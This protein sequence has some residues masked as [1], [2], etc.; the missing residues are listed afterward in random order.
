MQHD[1]GPSLLVA[2]QQIS[3]ILSRA[4]GEIA[5]TLGKLPNQEVVVSKPVL[6]ATLVEPVEAAQ[7]QAAAPEVTAAPPPLDPIPPPR[8]TIPEFNTVE[9]AA[10]AVNRSPAFVYG[11]INRGMIAKHFPFGNS[12]TMVSMEEVK[13][14]VE[15]ISPGQ[16][17]R[18][19]APA[20]RVWIKDAA[21]ELQMSM[22]GMYN[23]VKNGAFPGASQEDSKRF[24]IPRK[25]LD[26]YKR[27]IGLLPFLAPTPPATS[28]ESTARAEE[29]EP[30]PDLEPALKALEEEVTALEPLLADMSPSHRACQLAVWAGHARKLT[31]AGPPVGR[32]AWTLVHRLAPITAKYGAW[33]NAVFPS[34]SIEDW[35]LYI[36]ANAIDQ[37]NKPALSAIEEQVLVEGDLR[38]LLLRSKQVKKELVDQTL[39]RAKSILGEHS[40]L[41]QKVNRVFAARFRDEAKQLEITAASAARVPD[42]SAEVLA[43]TKGKRVLIIGGQGERDQHRESYV[44]QL[45]L[46]ECEWVTAERNK[47]QQINRVMERATPKNFDMLIYLTAF[48]GHA[49]NNVANA[50]KK[51]KLPVIMLSTGYSLAQVAQAIRDQY[52]PI[53]VVKSAA[54]K[55]AAKKKNGV[56]GHSRNGHAHG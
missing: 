29:P 10:K 21:A 36:R 31:D 12:L 47:A 37:T 30:K 15:K 7:A 45:Q 28:T 55:T 8:P 18:S 26:E 27:A 35:D 2:L 5:E 17:V 41:L 25:E 6:E 22:N 40:L 51:R 52:T 20:G 39:N 56:N 53:P 19:P 44:D 4:F 46:A 13:R 14:V 43:L 42:V 23:L 32:R 33:V 11:L 38:A 48:T 49:A 50:A 54:K 1:S 24:S 3:S 16:R 34:W 9:Q